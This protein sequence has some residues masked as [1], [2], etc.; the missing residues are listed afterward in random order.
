MNFIDY[1]KCKYNKKINEMPQNK[2]ELSKIVKLVFPENQYYKS[3]FPK[4]QI[5]LHHTASGRGVNGDFRYWLSTPERIATCVIIDY[6][7]IINQLFS[8]SY[9]GHHLGVKQE[10]LKS[11]GFNDYKTRNEQLNQ[12]SIAIEI[13]AWGGLKYKNGKW[14]AYPNN[15]SEEVSKDR[16]IEYPNGYRGYFGFEKYTNEQIESVRQLLVFWGNKYKIPLDYNEDMFEISNA[17]LSGKEG[18]WS[19]TSFREDKSDIFPQKELIDMLKN[20]KK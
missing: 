15:Y 3:L 16:V 7:G 17:A 2:L 12:Q 1:F 11:K 18:I 8:S 14:Y 20:L 13:D 10:F 5:I 19:H 9:W 4:K 6:Q